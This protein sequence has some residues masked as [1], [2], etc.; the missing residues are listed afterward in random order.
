MAHL[1]LEQLDARPRW[2]GRRDRAA[3][4]QRIHSMLVVT[5]IGSMI[6]VVVAAL[7]MTM[8]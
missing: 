3:D 2:A 6:V 8:F 4:M 1:D 5:A 7:F